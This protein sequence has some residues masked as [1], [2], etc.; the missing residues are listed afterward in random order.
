MGELEPKTSWP[1][2]P[3]SSEEGMC[4]QNNAESREG[5]LR[6]GAIGEERILLEDPSP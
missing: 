1:M 5:V 4:K 3:Y 2:I 6:H